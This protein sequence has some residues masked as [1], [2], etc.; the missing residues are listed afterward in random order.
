MITQ[1]QMKTSF[2][3]DGA[4]NYENKNK[5]KMRWGK[6]NKQSKKKDYQTQI[7]TIFNVDVFF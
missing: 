7:K 2:N 5:K 3:L 1:T 4:K 6:K